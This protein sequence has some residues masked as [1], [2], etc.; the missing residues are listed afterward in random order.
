MLE[1][2]RDTGWAR[3]AVDPA[4]TDWAAHALTAARR[5]VHDPKNAHWHQCQ[6]TWFVGVDVLDNDAS[7]R[8]DG[9]SPLSGKAVDFITADLGGWPA[10]HNA[11]ISVTYP[12]YPRPRVGES[13]AAF[14]YR[15]NR[16]A[17]HVDGLRAIGPERHRKMVEPH[18]FILGL[19]L[20]PAEPDAAPLV[21]W[22]GS[23]IIMRDAFRAAYAGHDPHS[24]Q[25]VDVTEPYL[26][27]R[28]LVFERCHRVRLSAVP[29]EALVLHRMALHGVA[30]WAAGAKAGADGRMIAYFRP[31]M[32]G[33]VASWLMRS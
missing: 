25:V 3:F 7:G 1:R 33:G 24:L 2:F 32:P 10:L 29:G 31:E 15:Q 9:S 11:Q 22:E 21:V 13:D 26:N 16:D 8:I 5:A 19:P 23:H 30:P 6:G 17:A 14:R 28:R 12:G 20:T 27:A 4:V 18:S